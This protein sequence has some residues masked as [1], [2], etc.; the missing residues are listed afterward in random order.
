M[1]A[2][3]VILA[4]AVA[5]G[6]APAARAHCPFC[7]SQGQTLSAEVGQAD[8]IVLGTLRNPQRDPDDIPKG[9]TD[10][11]IETVVKPHDYLR[12]KK[13][14][15]LPRFVPVDPQGN[16]KYLIFASL[17]TRPV[18]VTASAVVGAVSLGNFDAQ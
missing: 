9:T 7:A 16:N 18:D 17:Y 6:L 4:A 10:L 11:V 3:R 1:T 14:L 15:K 2:R 12:G 5:L 13:V 8:L